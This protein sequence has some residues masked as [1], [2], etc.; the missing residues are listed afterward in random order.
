DKQVLRRHFAGGAAEKVTRFTVCYRFGVGMAADS[1]LLNASVSAE[2]FLEGTN[3]VVKGDN[4]VQ[5]LPEPS[6]EIQIND[7]FDWP[8]IKRIR[9]QITAEVNAEADVWI[10][11]LEK[12]WTWTAIKFDH[13]FGTEPAF[14]LVPLQIAESSSSPLTAPAESFVGTHPSMVTDYYTAGDYA[15]CNGGG[16]LFAYTGIQPGT[17]M[18]LRVSP[19]A[20]P[21]SWVAPLDVATAGAILNVAVAPLPAGGWVMV[22]SEI[23]AADVGNPF[24]NARLRYA[25]SDAAGTT[26][27]APML[28]E[29]LDGATRGIYLVPAHPFIGLLYLTSNQG[30][31]SEIMSLY[32][33]T[34]TD[35]GW[36]ASVNPIADSAIRAFDAGGVDAGSGPEVL[37][38]WVDNLRTLRGSIWDGVTFGFAPTLSTNANN[39]ISVTAD[40]NGDFRVAWADF[41]DGIDLAGYK[42]IGGFTNLGTIVSNVSPS[43]VEILTLPDVRTTLVTWAEGGNFS[44]L[45]SA[46]LDENGM[47]TEEPNNLTENEV[48]QYTGLE[49]MQ[50]TST[51]ATLFAHTVESDIRAF[52]IVFGGT[53]LVDSDMDG[54]PDAHEFQIIDA[55]S[56][57]GVRVLGDVTPKGDFDGDGMSN[58]SEI[59]FGYDPTDPDSSLQIVEFTLPAED[60]AR[61]LFETLDNRTFTVLRNPDLTDTNGWTAVTNFMADGFPAR[62]D[63]EAPPEGQMH[64]RLEVE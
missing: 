32:A 27:S 36:S 34:W 31:N 5:I 42:A 15:L 56:G 12:N 61:L 17:G 9:G 23:D 41:S 19:G 33:R 8:F 10:T 28:I 49:L 51:Q 3:C 21:G 60:R 63:I 44:A 54:L 11:K 22:W 53:N 37:V 1:E 26:W 52:D 18:V 6:T 25:T 48:G 7:N 2:L 43:D 46:F 16:G 4:Q 59:L 39:A 55:D 29:T 58:E 50:T 57:D 38:S 47:T 24:P 40:A 64:Y 62:I 14:Q 35:P 13:S 45:W 20:G 30:P